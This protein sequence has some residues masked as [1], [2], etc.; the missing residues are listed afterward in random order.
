VEIF[1][2]NYGTLKKGEAYER[3]PDRQ[4]YGGQPFFVSEYGGA[5]WAP[6]DDDE[7]SWGYGNAPK[8]EKEFIKRYDGLTTSLLRAKGVCA[9][10]YTQLYDVEQEKNGLF[11]Y[12]R[13]KKFSDTVYQQI[14]AVNRQKAAIEE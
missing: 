6:E 13:K 4:K 9:L 8:T 7:N 5:R 1:H 12:D 11:T 2:K 14:K 10:C 3:M